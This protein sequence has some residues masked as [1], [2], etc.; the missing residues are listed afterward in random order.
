MT[1]CVTCLC[2][3]LDAERQEVPSH[4]RCGTGKTMELAKISV[5]GEADTVTATSRCARQSENVAIGILPTPFTFPVAPLTGDWTPV[6]SDTLRY[7][8]A[9]RAA[10]AHSHDLT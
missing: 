5:C 8:M 9:T 4:A 1:L 7:N 3:T 6:N 2:D 10:A